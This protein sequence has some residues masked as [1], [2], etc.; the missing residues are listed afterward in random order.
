M[1]QSR[2]RGRGE[3]KGGKQEEGALGK[4][5][6]GNSGRGEGRKGKDLGLGKEEKWT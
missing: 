5:G 1:S 4:N 6:K 2:R 3:S